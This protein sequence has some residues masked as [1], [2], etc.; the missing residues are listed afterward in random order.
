MCIFSIRAGASSYT[1]REGQMCDWLPTSTL[2]SSSVRCS[3]WYMCTGFRGH[4]GEKGTLPTAPPRTAGMLR[5]MVFVVAQ[6]CWAPLLRCLAAGACAGGRQCQ[7]FSQRLDQQGAVA[8]VSRPSVL[9]RCP[10]PSG[11]RLGH[12]AQSVAIGNWLW[13]NLGGGSVTGL[14]SMRA[15]PPRLA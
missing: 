6:A 10:G 1:E 13:P 2:A 4:F 3:V 5:L 11:L 12:E 7:A 14:H 8:M 9:L 15:G